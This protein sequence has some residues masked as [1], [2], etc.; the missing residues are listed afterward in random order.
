LYSIETKSLTKSFGD[1]V[2]VNDISFSVEKGE[3]FGFLG[4]NG[5]GK[6]TT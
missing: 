5:A 3:I 4:P 2:A 6:S 1:L